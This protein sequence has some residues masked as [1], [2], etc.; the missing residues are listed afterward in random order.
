MTET[1]KGSEV[2]VG[3]V[4]KVGSRWMRVTRNEGE[5]TDGSDYL[6]VYAVPWNKDPRYTPLEKARVLYKEQEYPVRVAEAPVWDWV[7]RELERQER[8]WA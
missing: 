3:Q 5:L 1:V 6:F 8:L 7:T 4:V 2:Q